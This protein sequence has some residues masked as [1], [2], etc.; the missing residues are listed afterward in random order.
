MGAPY[1]EPVRYRLL[2]VH[3]DALTIPDMHALIA[4]AVTTRER[5]TIVSQNL[6]SVYTLHHDPTLREMQARA[7]HIRIDGMPLILAGRLL[8]YPL[9]TRHRTG[10]MDWLDPFMREAVARGWRLYYLGSRPGVAEAG[11]ERLRESYPGLQIVVHHG[12]FDMTPGSAELARVLADIERARADVLIVGMGMPR[13]E[14]F[15]LHHGDRLSPPVCL[16]SGAAL[17]YVAGAIRTPP[18]WLGPIGLE[19]LYRLAS[20]PRRL[21]RRYLV[22]PWFVARLLLQDALARASQGRR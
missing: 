9:H 14:T 2:G 11:G 3:V 16:T 22:E 1:R 18:R 12:H 10:W 19:W 15:L 8:G 6:H 13:Q 20:E 7:T 17:D 4:R 21:W 5:L